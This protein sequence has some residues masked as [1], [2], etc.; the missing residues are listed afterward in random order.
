MELSKQTLP[1]SLLTAVRYEIKWQVILAN[2]SAEY[3]SCMYKK[4]RLQYTVYREQIKHKFGV[5][6]SIFANRSRMID[7]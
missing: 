3:Y 1:L 6:V 4:L 2:C 5:R 7:F